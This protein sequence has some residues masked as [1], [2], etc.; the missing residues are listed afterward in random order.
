M[1]APVGVAMLAVAH[2]PSADPASVPPIA[3]FVTSAFSPLAAAVADM[4]LSEA[5]GAPPAPPELGEGIA[6]VLASVT[7]DLATSA[8]IADAVSHGQRV[9]PLL[10][11]QS[12][13]NAVA[14]HIAARWGLA[15]PVVCSIPAADPMADAIGSAALLIEDGDATAALVVVASTY[16]DGRV[17]ATA[18]LIG[19]GKWVGD[20]AEEPALAADQPA[21]RASHPFTFGVRDAVQTPW[22][23]PVARGG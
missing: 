17:A 2:W 20:R 23:A 4:C 15:G 14:G 8:A 1:T 6:I 18:A 5:F 21:Q 9:P 3:G 16:G 13:P 22:Q 7:G 19:P 11:F 10:F 12:N